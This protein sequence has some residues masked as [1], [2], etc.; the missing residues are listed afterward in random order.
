MDE[1]EKVQLR[2]DVLKEVLRNN[3]HSH[4]GEVV[5]TAERYLGFVLEGKLGE[6]PNKAAA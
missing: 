4:A 3:P 2:F 6:E 5:K 1:K